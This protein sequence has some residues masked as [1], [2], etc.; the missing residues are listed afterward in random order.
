MYFA[1][2]GD[3]GTWPEARCKVVASRVVKDILPSDISGPTLILYKGE[4]QL[5]YQVG[6]REYFVWA[7]ARCLDKDRRFVEDKIANLPDD[8]DY[9][10]RYNPRDPSEAFVR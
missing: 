9:H 3:T 7:N 10:L 8:C 1:A 6:G 2:R 4:Y 5:A